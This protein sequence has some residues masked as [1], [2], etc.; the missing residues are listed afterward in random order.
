MGNTSNR[1]RNP[2]KALLHIP[3]GFDT[4]GGGVGWEV[5]GGGLGGC[6]NAFWSFVM[7]FEFF[8]VFWS[9]K[10]PKNIG[11]ICFSFKKQALAGQPRQHTKGF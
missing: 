1:V 8:D 9:L 6:F 3:E 5:G 11:S 10:N 4:E 2:N 7:F